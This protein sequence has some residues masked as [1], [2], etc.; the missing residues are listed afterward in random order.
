MSGGSPTCVTRTAE[1]S[2]SQDDVDGAFGMSP[3]FREVTHTHFPP[4]AF[5]LLYVLLLMLVG[6]PLFFLELVAGQSVRQGSIGVW[7]HVAPQLAGIGYSSCVVCRGTRWGGGLSLF[8][9]MCQSKIHRQAVLLENHVFTEA[10]FVYCLSQYF[11]VCCVSTSGIPSFS[12]PVYQRFPKSPCQ[13]IRD[14]LYLCFGMLGFP[15]VS[16]SVCQ[17]FSVSVTCPL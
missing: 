10:P 2:C 14:S 17:V 7:K 13:Y 1:V 8:A 6:V 11:R 4:G 9:C 3:P 12:M 15:C 16:V 5:L